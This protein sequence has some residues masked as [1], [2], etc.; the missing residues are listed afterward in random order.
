VL[1]HNGHIRVESEE[2]I[3]TTFVVHLP[4]AYQNGLKK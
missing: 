1:K 4:A 2:G 3:G